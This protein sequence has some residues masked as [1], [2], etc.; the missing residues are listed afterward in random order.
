MVTFLGSLVQSCC[1]ERGTLQTKNTGVCGECSPCLSHTGFA[2]AH[3]VC[4]FP[5]YTA[6]ILGCS[7]REL[8][9][10]GPGLHALPRSKPLR[11]RFS[12]TLQRHRLGLGLCFVPFPGPSSLGDQVLGEHGC[13]NLLPPLSL[14]LGFLGIQLAHLLREMLT[15]QN[16][17]KSWLATKPAC[18]LVDDA[19]LGP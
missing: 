8:S 5:V 12:G 18:S 7:A 15:I 19:S 3:G 6:Q 16:P 14:P 10:A 11:F 1:G 2:P 17:K 13:C 4:A 9:E